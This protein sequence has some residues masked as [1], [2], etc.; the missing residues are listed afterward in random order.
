MLS[1]RGVAK[2]SGLVL[3]DRKG[4][5]GSSR[6]Q[7]QSPGRLCVGLMAPPR[8]RPGMPLLE[9]LGS[10]CPSPCEGLWGCLGLADPMDAPYPTHAGSP[11][12]LLAPALSQL[13]AVLKHHV[14]TWEREEGSAMQESAGSA[15]HHVLCS[16][17]SPSVPP[18]PPLPFP[19]SRFSSTA[20]PLL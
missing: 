14:A 5:T 10:L 6:R 16:P 9:R 3:S 13:L 7:R 15:G 20:P 2:A 8:P 12:G 19:L 4:F 11:K 18:R 17:M 1:R